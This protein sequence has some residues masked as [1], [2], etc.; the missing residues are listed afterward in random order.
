[1]TWCQPISRRALLAASFAAVAAACRREPTVSV[2]RQ[3][4]SAPLPPGA[5]AVTIVEFDD[6]GQ[7]I[8]VGQA[9]RIVKTEAEWRE[10]LGTLGYTVTREA[11]TERPFT[12][13]LLKEHRTGL[14]RCVC[15][16][17]AVFASEAKFE[18]GTGWPSFYQPIAPENIVESPDDSYGMARTAVACAR[19]DAHLGHVFPDGPPPTGLRYCINSASLLFV[20]KR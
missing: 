20:P 12:G 9:D 4:V 18:S 11:G 17:T 1:M 15:C 5:N 16:E 8:N 7:R 14:F 13:P 10:Q 2:R 6:A 19:C 3:T